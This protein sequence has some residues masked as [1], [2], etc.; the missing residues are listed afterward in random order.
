M[1]KLL[2]IILFFTSLISVKSQQ[3]VFDEARTIYKRDHSFGILMHTAGLGA[4]YRYGRYLDGFS[5]RNFE[6]EMVGMKHEKQIK[7]FNPYVENG[8][9]YFYGK[10]NSL[11]ILRTSLGY[12]KAF[13]SKQN[14]RGVEINYL[15]QGGLSF[16][17]TKPI[18]LYV[19]QKDSLNK[20]IIDANGNQVYEAEKY[21]PEKHQQADIYGKASGMLGFFEGRFYPGGFLKFALNFES[22]RNPNKINAIE[23]GA[24]LDAYL[25][26]I[27]VMGLT[28]NRQFYLNLY[29]AIVFGSKKIE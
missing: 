11:T 8:R 19:F 28:E 4:F 24:T 25:S 16:G 22:S 23:V 2:F 20:Y 17:Y 21:D 6:V 13:I 26:K 10:K 9:G 7:S 5:K 1:K 18:Y 12:Q 15:V 3:T 29:A 14:V 27:P